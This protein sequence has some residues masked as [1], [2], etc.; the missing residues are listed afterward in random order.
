MDACH[1]NSFDGGM[2][3][4]S[5]IAGVPKVD[6]GKEA[7]LRAA[8]ALTERDELGVVA[9]DETAHWVVKTAPLGGLADLQGA[10]A[11]IQPMGQTNIFA[12][13]GPGG[14]LA[15]GRHRD[16]APHRPAHRRLVQQRPVRRDPRSA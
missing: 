13:P 3:G 6:I 7:I 15:R 12:G 11:G 2:G 4:G 1:C 8:S 14:G 9:F 5:G 16:P 10:I